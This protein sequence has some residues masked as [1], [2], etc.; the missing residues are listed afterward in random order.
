MDNANITLFKN[1]VADMLLNNRELLSA[2][3]IKENDMEKV[4]NI[5][6]RYIYP[7]PFIDE[8]QE[9]ERSIICYSLD[10][11]AIN[12]KNEYFKDAVLTFYI[13]VRS[14]KGDMRTNMGVQT[15][16]LAQHID[17]IF[18]WSDKFGPELIPTSNV[19]K[20]LSQNYHMR[21]LKYNVVAMNSLECGNKHIYE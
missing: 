19:E 21:V 5:M 1:K 11:P 6:Y 13:V 2:L 9:T 20:V 12:S 3:R 7:Y 10:F 18:A 15:D 14:K 17:N 4:G 8:V 16:V